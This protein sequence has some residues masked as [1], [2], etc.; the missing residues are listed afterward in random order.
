MEDGGTP[1]RSTPL[2]GEVAGTFW[3]GNWK[4]TAEGWVLYPWGVGRG[5]VI[6]DD[7]L[8]KLERRIVG[9][10]AG[11]L[12]AF[13][14]AQMLDSLLEQHG[15]LLIP[16]VLVMQLHRLVWS[17]RLVRTT[18]RSATR[19]S[20]REAATLQARRC[21]Q[22]V[23]V[24]SIVLFMVLFL[25]GFIFL[26]LFLHNPAYLL[27]MLGVFLL[28]LHSVWSLALWDEDRVRRLQHRQR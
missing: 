10:N 4:Y 22:H 8:D 24:L 14:V 18:K 17:V 15:R 13:F 1:H 3:G 12:V 16:V 6:P 5:C 21:G 25:A 19:M 2:L 28:G 27:A 11:C 9:M 26:G 23:I 20:Y 7:R